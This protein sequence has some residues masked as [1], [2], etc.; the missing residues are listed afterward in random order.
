MA[1]FL[2]RIGHFAYRRAW[3][4]IGAWILVLAALLGGGLALGGQ[5]AESYAIPGTESQETIDMLGAVFPQVSGASVEAVFHT[6]DG[7]VDD[8]TNKAAIEQTITAIEDIPGVAAAVSPFSEY[9]ANAVSDDGQTAIARV[10]LNGASTD[11]S[12]ATLDAL[13]GSGEIGRDAGMTVAFGGQVFQDTTF[14]LTIVEVFGVLFA[15][16]VL[17][18]TFG[19]LLAAGMPL[20]MALIGV[21]IATGGILAAAAFT[22]V[23]STAPML[24]VMLGLAVGIDYS[25]FILSRH[26]QQLAR[27]VE[28]EESAATAVATAGGAVVFAG[29]TVII[30]LLG[31]LVVGIPFLSTMGVAAAFA[32]FIAVLIAVTLLPAM[33]G[34][35]KGRMTPKAGSRAHRRALAD[36]DAKPTLGRRWVNTVLK[37]PIVAVVL[38]VGVL[39]TLA[40]PALSLDLNLPTG[41]AEPAGSTQR[42]AYEMVEDG[43]GPGANG[44]LI[45]VVDITQTTDIFTE[46]DA[47]RTELEHL[48]GVS[49]VSQ[50]LPNETVDT[51][52]IQVI[53]TTAPDDPATKTLVQDIRDL[54]PSIDAEYGTPIRVTGQTAVTIDISN[55]LSNALVP[56]ALVVVGLSIVLL[57][58][59]FR[60]LFVPVKAALGFLLSAFAAIGVTVAVFQWGW[61]ADLL[62]IEHTGPILSFLPILLMAVLFGL[63]M[64]YEVFLVSGMREEFV[65]HGKPREAIVH[66][67]QHSARVV[68]AAA[69][70]MFF[71]FF[72]FVPEGAGVIKGI[73][74]ALAIGVFFDAFLVR[75]TLVP[76]AM[77]LAGKAAWYLP[78]WLGRLLPNVDVEGEGLRA[79][80]G[81]LAW[82][83]AQKGALTAEAAYLGLPGQTMGP[84]SF[85]IEAGSVVTVQAPA[86]S[87]RVFAAS[88][89]GR[90]DPVGGRLQLHGSPLPSERS[91]AL[92]RVGL[93]DVGAGQRH[94]LHRTVGELLAERL[95]LSVPWYRSAAAGQAEWI[96]KINL[97]LRSTGTSHRPIDADTSMAS[98]SA[99]GRAT[100]LAASVLA[101]RPEVLIVDL[102]DA[103]PVD[104]RGRSIA[105]VLAVLAP[106]KT[107]I[108]LAAGDAVQAASGAMIGARP[109]VALAL[110]EPADHD[111]P[112]HHITDRDVPD[113]DITDCE[114]LEHDVPAQNTVATPD[115][116][117]ERV[118]EEGGV[119]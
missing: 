45:V 13:T 15:G 64:D 73:A 12:Q 42:A 51:A 63:A 109:T 32:V 52:I 30:A 50:G 85:D 90:L 118:L 84:L 80:L 19:S 110:P 72:G 40:V 48:D 88:L 4:V 92:R 53:P 98:L 38:V 91:R 29:I 97:A 77:A 57:M 3:T 6:T 22:N 39:G 81:D 100:V 23:S 44:P 107:T 75:M 119:R 49:F 89:A 9:A 61:F 106:V 67:F 1:I 34:L 96:E 7:S 17:V 105:Q 2:Y 78:K 20:L 65:R 24:A 43:F 79:H 82:A 46:L 93:V 83:K 14:G 60:S 54:A 95:E 27:G 74:F 28:P 94:D 86:A 16:V 55:R 59:V 113:H 111:I 47:I 10:Q 18:I 37:A 36:D 76:A 62:H 41:A 114:E 56:F 8:A 87:R 58:M 112:D 5:M 31:L 99:L 115:A 35:I 116:S 69:L 108:V 103:L 68:T 70:I 66:G 71:V 104:A 33:L 25:L 102:G 21:G 11:V 101:E 26:R 117:E